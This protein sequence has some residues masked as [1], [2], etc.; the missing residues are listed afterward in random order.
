MK[1]SSILT[2]SSLLLIQSCSAGLWGSSSKT[3]PIVAEGNLPSAP[4][5]K[6]DYKLSFKKNFY[7]NGSVPFWTTGGGKQLTY[8]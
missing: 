8:M 7:Y 3:D 5:S 2:V 1:L 6:F 4:I